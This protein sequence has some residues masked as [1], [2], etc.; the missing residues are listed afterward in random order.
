[1]A[2]AERA[3]KAL[4]TFM[5]DYLAPRVDALARR[6]IELGAIETVSVGMQRIGLTDLDGNRITLAQSVSADV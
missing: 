6:G 2:D 1:V 5:V 4:V 3:G